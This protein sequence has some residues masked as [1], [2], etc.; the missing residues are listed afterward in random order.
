LQPLQLLAQALALVV[1]LLEPAQHV[2]HV[3]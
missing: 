2:V 1:Q 3:L